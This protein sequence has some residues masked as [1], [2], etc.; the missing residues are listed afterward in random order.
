M[1]YLNVS[2]RNKNSLIAGALAK[3]TYTILISLKHTYPC[4][5]DLRQLQNN[6][7]NQGQFPYHL[8]SRNNFL[9]RI[10]IFW[11]EHKQTRKNKKE[12]F[13]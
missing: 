4:Q 12:T 7:K 6:Q 9:I 10:Y 5:E 2:L 3:L 8:S 13:R 11:A 1:G